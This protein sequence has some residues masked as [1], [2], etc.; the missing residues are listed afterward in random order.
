MALQWSLKAGIL[1]AFK[2]PIKQKSND[3]W[4]NLGFGLFMVSEICKHLNGSFCLIS[5]DNYILI[6]NQGVN[7]QE[8]QL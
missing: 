7:T 5:H 3:I 1:D 6:D 4:T 8:I 2:A